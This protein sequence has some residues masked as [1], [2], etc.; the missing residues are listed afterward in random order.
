MPNKK[1]QGLHETFFIWD[2]FKQAYPNAVVRSIPRDGHIL[3]IAY[4]GPKVDGKHSYSR[5]LAILHPKGE[6]LP[7]QFSKKIKEGSKV[8]GGEVRANP[9]I[10]PIWLLRTL[11]EKLTPHEFE[12][13][14]KLMRR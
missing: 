10:I 9:K 8:Q 13:A 3:K 6:N 7:C 5:V 11:R 4:Y 12:E 14:I 1:V 2:A